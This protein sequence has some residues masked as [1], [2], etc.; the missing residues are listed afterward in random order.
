MK[1]VRGA[2]VAAVRNA[3]FKTF[4]LQTTT[5][6]RRKNSQ[7]ILGWKKSKKVEESYKKLFTDGDVI[8]NITTTAF[9][10]LNTASDDVFSDM[11]I[12]TAAVCDIILNPDNPTIEVLKKSLELRMRRF[13]VFVEFTFY[14]KNY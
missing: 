14:F 3:I 12:Y 10:Y 5:T 8:E 6:I 11:Y 7:D 2:H 4:G 13:K 1:D 9:P